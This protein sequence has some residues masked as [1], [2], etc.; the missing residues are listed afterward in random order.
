M[1]KLN[2][3]QR[4][5]VES[6]EGPIVI[7]AGPGTGKTKTLTAR[8][9]HLVQHG[10]DP[11]KILALTFTVKAAR[12]MH[13]RV[14]LL[15]DKVPPISTIHALG[16]QVLRG[17]EPDKVLAFISEGDRLALLKSLTRPK[18][19]SSL[20][21]R[22]LALAIS[23]AKGSVG[24]IRPALKSV[25][26]QYQAALA[27]KGLV[28]FDDLLYRAHDLLNHSPSLQ[29]TWQQ[30]Y[31]YILIDEFQDTSELQWQLIKLILGNDNILVIGDPKQSIYGFRG[32]SADMF[33]VFRQDF[34]D[35]TEITLDINYRSAQKIVAIASAMFP[36]KD[37]LSAYSKE[38]GSV[39]AIRTM[40]ELSEAD[41][42]LSLIEQGIGGSDLLK[43][44]VESGGRRFRDFAILYRT[45][46][47]ARTV[48]RKLHDSG[49]PFQVVG[50]GSPYEQPDIQAIIGA[51][52]WFARGEQ[53][54]V[55]KGFSE[56]Q[57]RT[58][59]EGI[60]VAQPVSHVAQAVADAFAFGGDDH[61]RQRVSQFIG[62]LVRFDRQGLETCADY[63][64]Q[65]R[66]NDFYDPQA[67][68]V[69]LL[70]IHASKGLEFSHVI[71]I[72][73]EEGILPHIR[74]TAETDFDEERRLFYVAVT[75]AKDQLDIVYAKKRGNEPRE[76]SRFVAELSPEVLPRE[77][78]PQAAQL[79]KKLR[80]R[81]QKARQSTLF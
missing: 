7:V 51:L 27:E 25:L 62:T 41:L 2:E 79:E 31:S 57:V 56:G 10:V 50:E 66:D 35:C 69:T 19:L 78:D 21:A 4:Q 17:A 65:I 64:E 60:D 34:P 80:R 45:H 12:E 48:Q 55:V 58:L 42:V 8:I 68:A 75:R 38:Q 70:T 67:D 23:N 46:Q 63:F 40:N 81:E 54:P 24:E 29:K 53:V 39:R 37:A 28:D 15:V 26:K 32:A 5:A 74:K 47:A 61:K 36:G 6:G 13:E 49:I 1:N 76:V 59:L 9:A 30:K 33:A 14:E 20:P 73:A 16:Y 22:D 11:E 52:L 43:A 44:S 77:D 18:E 72:A 3:K 71:L